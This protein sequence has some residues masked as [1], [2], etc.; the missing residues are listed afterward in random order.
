M[1]NV[2]SSTYCSKGIPSGRLADW[3]PVKAPCEHT[4]NAHT[5]KASTARMNNKGARGHPCLMPR[6]G[7]SES[8]NN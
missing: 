2:V 1:K 6:W 8:S 3:N 4:C 5:A 7:L